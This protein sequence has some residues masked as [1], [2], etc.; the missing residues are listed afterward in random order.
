VSTHTHT[1]TRAQ[2][3]FNPFNIYLSLQRGKKEEK[4]RKKGEKRVR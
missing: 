4:E 1:H 3:A 2:D